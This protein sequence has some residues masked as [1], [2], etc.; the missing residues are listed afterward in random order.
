MKR[1]AGFSLFEMMIVVAIIAILSAALV[2]NLMSS[3]HKAEQVRVESDISKIQTQVQFYYLNERRLPRSMSDLVPDYL[4]SVPKDPWG[5]H[6]VH[7][8]DNRKHF[9]M[10]YGRDG[11]AGGRGIDSDIK[12]KVN[13]RGLRR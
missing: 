11:V 4:V 2:P 10:S 5:N 3:L 13:L 12:V 1:Q 8:R 9:I 7:V 6:Y